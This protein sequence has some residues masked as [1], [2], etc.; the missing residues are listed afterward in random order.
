MPLQIIRQDITSMHVDAIVNTTNGAK[1]GFSGVDLAV[2]T[3]V[4]P[5]LDEECARLPLLGVGEAQI[6]NGHGLPCKYIIHTEGPVWHG[7]TQGESDALRS[8]YINSLELAVRYGCETVAFP[9]I[10]SGAY[11]YPKDQAL[12]FAVQTITAFLLEHEISVYLCVFDKDSYTFSQKLFCDIRSFIDEDYVEDQGD[13]LCCRCAPSFAK[14]ASVDAAPEGEDDL[15][16]PA[17]GAKG[18]GAPDDD[19]RK[20]IEAYLRSRDKGFREMLFELIDNSGMTDVECYKR[21]NVDKRT[22]SKIKSNKNYRPSKQTAIAFAIALRLDLDKTQ[23]LLGT[24]G[25]TLSRS[26]V[27][28]KIILYF[29]HQG[30]YDIF[31]I[32]EALF[33]F[34]QPLLGAMGN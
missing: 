2:H 31:E 8:C 16:I 29:I 20:R 9:L 19:V 27:F 12:K 1:I 7:G 22:F 30:N 17:K 32:N 21:A 3:L 6:T 5:A 14:C 25:F 13:G 24:L 23:A 15:C 26:S 4:G 10:S 18:Y 28:D 33:A 34:D 11:G